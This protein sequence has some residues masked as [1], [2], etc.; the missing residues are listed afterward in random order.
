MAD[1]KHTKQAFSASETDTITKLVDKFANDKKFV[2]SVAGYQR[3]HEA[4]LKKFL[5]ANGF[6]GMEV[7]VY[8]RP[9]TQS[10][11]PPQPTCYEVC[12]CSTII[13]G[14]CICVRYCS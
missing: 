8:K 5:E 1:T 12:L 14:L 10:P 6:E 9:T 13:P 11:P 7:R 3:G 4:E 2:D